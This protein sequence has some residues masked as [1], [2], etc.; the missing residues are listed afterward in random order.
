MLW[1]VETV[2]PLVQDAVPA[3]F[4]A[5]GAVPPPE[6]TALASD[7]ISVPG[8]L[9]DVSRYFDRARVFV[10]PLRAGAGMKGK[11]GMAMAFGLP[12]VTTSVG[13]EGMGLVDG[14]HALVADDP[15]SFAEAVV[16]CIATTSCGIA[17]RRE[18]RSA[19]DPRVVS[20]RDERAAPRTRRAFRR[21]QGYAAT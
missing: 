15:A 2:L 6:I 4:D 14:T 11:I 9:D 12:V 18:A 19:R 1:F 13:A 5:L 17:F 10:S 21:G 7:T 16:R 20:G 8:H 3:R